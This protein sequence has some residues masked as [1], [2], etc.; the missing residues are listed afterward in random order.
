[1]ANMCGICGVVAI[2]HPP[3]TES[4]SRMAAALAHRGPDGEG[5]FAADGVAL[6]SRRLAII[7]LSDAGMQPF[8]ADDGSLQLVYNGEVYNYR[9]LRRELEQSGRRF[10]SSTDTEVVLAAYEAWGESCV[11]RFEG[12]WAFALWDA[13]RQTLFCSR[14]RFGIKPFYYRLDGDR[15]TFAS[16]PKAFR[17]DRPL[18]A[19]ENLIRDYLEQGWLDHT[20]ETCFADLRSLPAASCLTFGVDGLRLWRYWQLQPHARPAGKPASLARA[21]FLDS[22]RLH[23]R[24]DVP[25]GT[26]L[27]GGLDSSAIVTSAAHLLQ[28]E[29][30][31]TAA[32]GPRQRT[33]T[34]YFDDPAADER[35]F[36]EAVVDRTGAEP[37][38]VTFSA[39]ELVEQL[40]KIVAAQDEPFG[41][42]SIAAQWF[43]MRAAR[44]AGLKVMLDGQGGDEILA[45]YPSA[46]SFRFADLIAHARLSAFAH[47]LRSYRRLHRT[48]LARTAAVVGRGFL[49][50]N[51]ERML[52]ARLYASP[53]LIAPELRA[54]P[55]RDDGEPGPYGDR[56]RRR[57]VETL[58]RRGLPG[59]L[60]YEDRNSMAHSLES[61]VPFLDHRFVELVFSFGGDELLRDG[62]TKALLRN[63]F[64]DLLPAAVRDRPDK[65]G[66]VTPE[67][68]WLRGPLGDLAEDVFCSQSFA[69]RGWVEPGAALS[70]LRR[71]RRGEINAGSELWRALNLELWAQAFLD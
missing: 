36:A 42:T 68:A 60:R 52:R 47:E 16:E 5:F 67:A 23:L 63:A 9:E 43:V 28:Q 30:S 65:L 34:A 56:L 20:D 21:A 19:N 32:L 18:R 44:Q 7:D 8:A 4:V 51:V 62:L 33:V 13:R 27:S 64:A 37:E 39:T 50:A 31:A 48:S 69:D 10:R 29:P 3:E 25:I 12:M 54:L 58:T 2:D 6:G 14:D 22:M 61:R 24:S 26:C 57:L 11:D 66:F 59:L 71:H 17:V 1:M 46:Y 38:W 53:T 45:G 55:R 49:P 35:R 40:P 70:R 15:F 41:S